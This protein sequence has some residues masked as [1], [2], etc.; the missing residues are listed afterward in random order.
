MYKKQWLYLCVFA[1]VSS[2]QRTH[3][4]KH[5]LRTI[6]QGPFPSI[7]ITDPGV[8]CMYVCLYECVCVSVCVFSKSSSA[9]F[10]LK[11]LIMCWSSFCVGLNKGL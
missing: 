7:L 10:I 11:Y 8:F 1:C 3:E 6:C 5:D 2:F 4:H 9:P